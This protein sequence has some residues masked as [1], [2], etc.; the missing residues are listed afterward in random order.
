[1]LLLQFLLPVSASFL[2]AAAHVAG[3][4]DMVRRLLESLQIDILA[5]RKIHTWN[6]P[7]SVDVAL[8]RTMQ[9]L[10]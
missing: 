8:R 1:M 9:W 6:P 3:K 7:G 5:T 4:V 10:V 2:A